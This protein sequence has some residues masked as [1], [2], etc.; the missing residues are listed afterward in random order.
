MQI[1]RS[2]SPPPSDPTI[3]GVRITHPDRVLYPD[4][5]LTKRELAAYYADLADRI[6]PHVAGR[7]LSDIYF[8]VPQAGRLGL[9]VSI[10]S[11]AGVVRMGVGTDAGL[12]PDP[13]RIVDGFSAE[14]DALAAGA[15]GA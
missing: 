5:G 2:M 8:W 1:A 9:G 11:Y 13:E 14:L 6:L 4:Q 10:F 3:A 7:P 12:V 15:G